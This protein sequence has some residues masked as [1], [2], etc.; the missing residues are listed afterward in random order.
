MKDSNIKSRKFNWL[1]SVDSQNTDLLSELQRQ[2][3]SMYE[4]EEFRVTYNSLIGF[5]EDFYKLDPV[6]IAFQNWL[7]QLQ[8]KSLLEYG[9]GVGRIWN[10]INSVLHSTKYTGIEVDSYSIESNSIRFPDCT[11]IQGSVYQE[12]LVPNQNYEVVFCFYVLEHL[13]FPAKA[14]DIMFKKVQ[15]GGNLVLVFP[16]FTRSGRLPSQ[17]LG[18]GNERTAKEKL[19]RGKLFDAVLSLYD[20]RIRLRNALKKIQT[21]PGGFHINTKPICLQNGIS[22]VWPDFD[23]VYIAN[24]SD[25]SHWAQEVGGQVFYPSG[26]QSPFDEHSFM[27]IKK[28]Q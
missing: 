7:A 17:Q 23:A 22:Q 2:M 28:P 26:I 15:P 19:C 6:T 12:D 4:S 20:S 1:S 3:N 9:C 13:V 25:I 11:W 10:H 16:D 14:L 27:Q 21:S 18:W 5:K 24:R 8:P